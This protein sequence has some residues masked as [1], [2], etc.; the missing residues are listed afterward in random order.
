VADPDGDIRRLW[1]EL[2][3]VAGAARP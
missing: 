2:A 3:P 1:E